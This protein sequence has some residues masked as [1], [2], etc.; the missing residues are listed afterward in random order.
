METLEALRWGKMSTKPY[1]FLLQTLPQP[2]LFCTGCPGAS[3]QSQ[4]LFFLARSIFVWS[5]CLR[6]I[7]LFV[8]LGTEAGQFF[9]LAPFRQHEPLFFF[10]QCAFHGVK[11]VNVSLQRI[12]QRVLV[13]SAACPPQTVPSSQSCRAG[14][15]GVRHWAGKC[16]RRVAHIN[17]SS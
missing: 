3:W 9:S 12:N 11:L 15:G 17:S 1:L 13:N 7:P 5:V 2:L 8:P 14:P 16:S 4:H 10:S 6:L